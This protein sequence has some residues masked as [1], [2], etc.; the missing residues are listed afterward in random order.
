MRTFL[1]V[2]IV[3]ADVTAA[4]AIPQQINY[5]GSLTSSTGAA[6]DTTVAMTFKLYS[7]TT[8]PALWTETRAAV[9]V[10]NGLFNVKLGEFTG[11]TDAILNNPQVWLGIAVGGDAEMTPRARIVSVG[12][13]YR[14][15]T[16]DG[17]TGGTITGDVMINNKL[18]VGA[19][20]SNPGSFANVLGQN[21]LASGN[22]A[23]VGGG[24]NN[25]ARGN[26]SMVG[27]GGPSPSDSNS[28]PGY[29][30]VIGGGNWNQA[31]GDQS[32]IGGGLS[33]LTSSFYTTVAGGGNNQATDEYAAVGGGA[34]NVASFF[35]T[36]IAGGYRNSASGYYSTVS[37]GIDNSATADYT[38]VPGGQ[39]CVANGDHS[40][41]AGRN[42]KTNSNASG[43][44]VWGDNSTN[45]TMVVGT[46]NRV[47]F[48]SANG[49]RLYTASDLSTGVS[50]GAGDGAWSSISDSTKKR[51]RRNVDTR[52]ILE[53][54]MATPIQQWSYKSQDPSIEHI[55]PMAQDFYA[56]FHL[57]ESDTTIS[58]I[59]PDGVMLAAIQELAKRV[60]QLTEQ[61]QIQQAQIQ[62][63]IA[64]KQQSALSGQKGQ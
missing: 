17:A 48:R 20:N 6:L 14:V 45:D 21:N 9:T 2:M 53:K 7:D 23:F 56:A 39:N 31:F 51:N 37:G 42:A 58:T 28:A 19:G 5:Q 30:A 27:G 60:E 52:S 22:H 61:N 44:F 13:A 50:M 46:A 1:F 55:G 15:G 25:R 47:V 32:V 57:G 59:D 35:A 36:T 41:V 29:G 10:Q 8:Q 16:V 24:M 33:N 54:V 3:F 11:L 12:Y 34:D 64:E 40:F 62:S 38:T 26:Y 43:S 49:Y 18:N 4:L 63:L